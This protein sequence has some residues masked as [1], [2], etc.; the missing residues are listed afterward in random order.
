MAIIDAK[1]LETERN[2]IY[3]KSVSG[4]RL[5]GTVLQNKDVF[6]K[7]PQLIMTKY[8][9]LIDLLI[10]LNIDNLT[11]SLS[12]RYT[13]D[14]ADEKIAEETND[15]VANVSID[16]QTGIITITNKDG[17]SSVIDTA[18]E[19]VPA[20]FEFI[21]DEDADK[22]YI[23]VT[24][25]DGSSTQTEVTNLMNQFTFTTSDIIGF[26]QTKNGTTTTVTA[27]VKNGSIG[28]SQLNSEV[29]TY[30]DNT[31]ASVATDKEIV[32]S[33]KTEVLNASSTVTANTTIV[34]NAKDDAESAALTSKS[35]AVG[36]TGSRTSEDTDNAEYYAAQANIRANEAYKSAEQARQYKDQAGQIVGGDFMPKVADATV[37]NIPILTGDGEL[38]D[39]GKNIDDVGSGSGGVFVATYGT[40]T[41]EEVEQAIEA[42]KKVYVDIGHSSLQDIPLVDWNDNKYTFCGLN[43]SES[44]EPVAVLDFLYKDDSTWD[45]ANVVQLPLPDYT[46]SEYDYKRFE[47]S[48]GYIPYISVGDDTASI[49][50]GIKWREPPKPPVPI[51]SYGDT[52]I[53]QYSLDGQAPVCAIY[54][55]GFRGILPMCNSSYTATEVTYQFCGVDPSGN[56]FSTAYTYNEETHTGTWA[57][58]IVDKPYISKPTSPTAGNLPTLTAD[59]EL[60]DSGKSVSDFAQT[61]TQTFTLAADSWAEDT[62]NSCYYY[63]VCNMNLGYT[64]IVDLITSFDNYEEEEAAWS[65][66][67]KGKVSDGSMMLLLYASEAPAIDLIIQVKVVE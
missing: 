40:T 60:T 17:T 33:A 19:K 50:Y 37:G 41:A 65:K 45:F 53:N 52:G 11:T 5:T 34:L 23:K 30:I 51:W 43:I 21:E 6:D 7:F 46:W 12:D 10:A 48:N 3:V 2:A 32:L 56:I 58:I 14:E 18:L 24:N 13:K 49:G 36:G 8:N 66:V 29:K 59:G 42:G 55:S 44:G 22:Y 31:V 9:N 20:T 16:T 39:S 4:E 38:T 47:S 62:E 1:I 35:Y 67:F 54:E 63:E 26:S 25:V 27:T 64:P 61:D 28:F 57:A 15:L